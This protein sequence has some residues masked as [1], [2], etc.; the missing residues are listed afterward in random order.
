M[1]G[2][3]LGD[4]MRFE[5]IL[6]LYYDN[7]NIVLIVLPLLLLIWV[8]GSMRSRTDDILDYK[9]YAGVL[10]KTALDIAI[11]S[12][13]GFVLRAMGVKLKFTI[14][15]APILIFTSLVIIILLIQV[16][17]FIKTHRNYWDIVK[18]TALFLTYVII[19]ITLMLG[20]MGR[21]EWVEFVGAVFS[22]TGLKIICNCSKFFTRTEYEDKNK[23]KKSDYPILEEEE[24]F[25]TRKT[26]L[27]RF[28]GELEGLYNEPY[29]VMIS[30][31]WGS[32]K[33]SF[34]NALEKNVKNAEFVHVECG[35]ERSVEGVL[36]SISTQICEIL[37]KNKIYIGKNSSVEEYFN[38]I[39]DVVG[40]TKYKGAA[41]IWHRIRGTGSDNYIVQK[42]K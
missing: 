23:L 38:K 19:A 32:G 26:Q 40:A 39:V 31:A 6:L 13:L 17:E 36:N 8:F 42:K 7:R 10:G 14:E 1:Q 28:L 24:L 11:T 3:N 33:T 2:A 25:G 4:V 20:V 16:M 9:I 41:Q 27:K 18:R 5:N 29:A 15:S 21:L 35:I 34:V 22:T 30:G 37:I 12:I